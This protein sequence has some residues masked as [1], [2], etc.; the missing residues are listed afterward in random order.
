MREDSAAAVKQ[1]QAQGIHIV[2]CTG[3]SQ[4]AAGAVAKDLGI[5]A[6]HAELL[7]QD[8]LQIVQ[9]LQAQGYK[10]GMVGDGVNDRLCDWLW[11]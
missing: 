8:K 6:V 10:V 3:D 9:Q 7:P 4:A 11:Y 1:L 2:M 5:D